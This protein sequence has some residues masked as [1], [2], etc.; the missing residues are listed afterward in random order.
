MR[1]T[2]LTLGSLLFVGAAFAQQKPSGNPP[3]GNPPSTPATVKTEAVPA[4]PA[5]PLTDAQAKAMLDVTGEVAMKGQLTNGIM[6][7]VHA[8]MPF[9]PQDANDDLVQSFQ[10]LDLDTPIIAIYKQHISVE[11][12]DAIIAFYKTP[13]GKNMMQIY[14]Q[15]LLQSQQAGVQLMRKTAQEALERHRPEIEAAAKQY[16]E[17]HAPRPAPTLNTPGA[18]PAP[19]PGAAKSA[20]PAGSSGSSAASNSTTQPH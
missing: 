2:V 19:A 18:K 12:A 14:P 16:R 20:A 17:E 3:S 10:K 9:L 8:S 13:A 15:L 11:D 5:H 7:Y 6:N 4:P 1:I